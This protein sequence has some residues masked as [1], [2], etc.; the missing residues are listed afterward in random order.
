MLAMGGGG[1]GIFLVVWIDDP[2]PVDSYDRPNRTRRESNRRPLDCESGKLP[3]L[4]LWVCSKTRYPHRIEFKLN[5]ILFG[6]KLLVRDFQILIIYVFKSLSILCLDN[7]PYKY[8]PWSNSWLSIL[9]YILKRNR[10]HFKPLL[11]FDTYSCWGFYLHKHP[12]SPV[13]NL[14]HFGTFLCIWFLDMLEWSDWFL[15]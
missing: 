12:N 11:T 15:S 7:I 3:T 14:L 8:I 4:P 5:R 2:R 6:Y 9:M 1:G 13:E 10:C